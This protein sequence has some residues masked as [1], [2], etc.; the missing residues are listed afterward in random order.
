MRCVVL[1]LVSSSPPILWIR[2]DQVV[3]ERQSSER[4]GRRGLGQ[5]Q[6]LEAPPHLTY[7]FLM[8]PAGRGVNQQGPVYVAALREFAPGER[9]IHH[10]RGAVGEEVLERA[11][12]AVQHLIRALP[13]LPDCRPLSPERNP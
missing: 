9:P 5:A 13:R 11:T 7:Q 3:A 1:R 2:S 10:K 8:P 6:P 4:S 12:Q